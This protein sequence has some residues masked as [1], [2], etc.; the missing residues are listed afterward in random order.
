MAQGLTSEIK[1]SFLLLLDFGSQTYPFPS[2]SPV[3]LHDCSELR[4]S[5]QPEYLQETKPHE[6]TGGEKGRG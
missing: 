6:H 1:S 5:Q 3:K 2:V 4:A